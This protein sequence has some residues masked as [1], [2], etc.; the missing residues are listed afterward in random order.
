ME[1]Q[2]DI[3]QTIELAADRARYDE[4]AKK[5]LTY[6]AV[7]A[8]ILKSCTKEFS[9]YS[10]KFICDNCLNEN[11]ELS[12][13]A[14]HQD[15]LNR[16]ERLNGDKRLDGLNTEANAIFQM[17]V[18]IPSHPLNYHYRIVM[19]ELR[20]VTINTKKHPYNEDVF[21]VTSSSL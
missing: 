5:L 2:T 4:C 12:E 8:W 6:K 1:R 15:Q 17:R 20:T 7:I 10:V 16:D 18:T 3:A 13:H 9:Q 14:V 11:V 19:L 21:L